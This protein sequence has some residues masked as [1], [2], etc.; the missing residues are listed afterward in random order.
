MVRTVNL[1][2]PPPILQIQLQRVQYD[3][4]KSM[5]FKSQAHL[6][7]E[8]KIWLDRYLDF[9]PAEQSD[10]TRLEKRKE[11]K[12]KR[13]EIGELRA[14][15][16]SLKP[17]NQV[18]SISTPQVGSEFI[19][20]P[21]FVFIRFSFSPLQPTISSSLNAV[22]SYLERLQIMPPPPLIEETE[23]SVVAASQQRLPLEPLFTLP[24]LENSSFF[25]QFLSEYSKGL[26][27]EI[28]EC[29]T[30]ISRLKAEMEDLWNEEMRVEYQ[31]VSVF[32]H[33]GE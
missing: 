7:F 3:R 26:E 25:P 6:A 15:I 14:R 21:L 1:V 12:I 28:A 16:K 32:M 13:K 23:P 11:S 29:E 22:S 30:R 31:L 18:S 5:L 9:N 19:D 2:D 27:Q 8:E 20:S 4:E 33:R 24:I 10:V 17:A